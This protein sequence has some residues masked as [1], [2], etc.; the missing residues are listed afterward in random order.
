MKKKREGE[1]K[2]Q[3]NSTA[4]N[5]SREPISRTHEKRRESVMGISNITGQ[6]VSTEIV[7]KPRT[8]NMEIDETG[9]RKREDKD[10]G[11]VQEESSANK[12]DGIGEKKYVQTPAATGVPDVVIKPLREAWG[13]GEQ[14]KQE[15]SENQEKRGDKTNPPPEISPNQLK[16]L[17]TFVE[18]VLGDA[19]RDR[20]V[21]LRG[22]SF[23][24]SIICETE[25]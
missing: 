21:E 2:K 9:K 13:K 23:Q 6:P 11:V 24:R 1:G 7:M 16:E 20:S 18:M 15:E 3:N 22:T 12:R 4:R 10:K 19:E 5:T 17:K 14:K 25:N 8:Q